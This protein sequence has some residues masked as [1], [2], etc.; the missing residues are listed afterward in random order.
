MF[1]ISYRIF[2]FQFLA[3]QLIS[4]SANW[5]CEF[6]LSLETNPDE[7]LELMSDFVAILFSEHG[8]FTNFISNFFWV[9]ENKIVVFIK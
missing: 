2:F 6:D 8:S 1:L 7:N 5:T 9:F 4:K 3:P